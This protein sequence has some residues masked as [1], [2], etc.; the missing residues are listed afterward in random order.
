MDTRNPGNKMINLLLYRVVKIQIPVFT[1][2]VYAVSVMLVSIHCAWAEKGK[3]A[4]AALNGDSIDAR[5]SAIH[6]LVNRHGASALEILSAI[7]E[8]KNEDGMLRMAAASAM[9]RLGDPA[10][11]PVLIKS[12]KQDLTVRTGIWSAII[13]ALGDLKAVD[14]VPILIKC[15][16]NLDDDWLGRSMAARA[17]GDIGAPQAIP[18][19]I[20][21]TMR[22][23]TRYDAFVALTQIN[24]ARAVHSLIEGMDDENDPETVDVCKKGLISLGIKALPELIKTMN[25]YTKEWPRTRLRANVIDILSTINHPS[26][27]ATMK[28]AL[29][30]PEPVIRTRAENAI[31]RLNK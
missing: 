31:R 6:E 10:A 4:D 13:P 28:D 3:T 14:A 30:D 7:L 20:A 25:D 23:D 1:A 8:N 19:L 11:V 24:D 5:I 29:K 22:A 26:A 21:A 12:L 2:I 18:A 15:L 17:L 9:G 27:I 16:N